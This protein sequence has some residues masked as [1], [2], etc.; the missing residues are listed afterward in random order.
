MKNETVV[1]LNKILKCRSVEVARAHVEAILLIESIGTKASVRLIGYTPG[2][3]YPVI[4]V[5]KEIR[6]I[7]GD[8]LRESKEMVEN[9]HEW[10]NL[11]IEKARTVFKRLKEAG[12]DVRLLL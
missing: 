11:E 5:I 12:A 9:G 3:N 10:P 6:S 7:F 1:L 2:T 8:G 4:N